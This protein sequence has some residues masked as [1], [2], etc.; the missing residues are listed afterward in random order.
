MCLV[1]TFFHFLLDEANVR[2]ITVYS[3]NSL[4]LH[5]FKRK[6]KIALFSSQSLASKHLDRRSNEVDDDNFR[7]DSDD[8]KEVV[9]THSLTSGVD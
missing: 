3:V 5:S 4:N 6:R 2:L 1:L 9:D 7:M 8:H